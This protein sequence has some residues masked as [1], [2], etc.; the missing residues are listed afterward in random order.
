MQGR[1][2]MDERKTDFT[3]SCAVYCKCFCENHTS[4]PHIGRCSKCPPYKESR[5]GDYVIMLGF[6]THS[7]KVKKVVTELFKGDK[8]RLEKHLERLAK[9]EFER[10]YDVA[11][12]PLP[13]KPLR[14]HNEK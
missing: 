14:R 2:G 7:R 6:V 1:N 4:I 5:K 13:S 12:I 8:K 3:P 10:L 9:E 11:R